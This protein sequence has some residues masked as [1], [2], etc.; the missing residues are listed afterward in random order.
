MLHENASESVILGYTSAARRCHTRLHHPPCLVA[1]V[2]AL[3]TPFLKPCLRRVRHSLRLGSM[4][5]KQSAPQ[6]MTRV[7]MPTR[8]WTIQQRLYF[9]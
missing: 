9:D 1:P 3:R 6:T 2:T 4:K 8:H 5:R 7:S